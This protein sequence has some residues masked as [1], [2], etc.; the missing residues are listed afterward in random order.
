MHFV[1]CKLINL[2]YKYIWLTYFTYTL[3]R[4]QDIN[5]TSTQTWL[6]Y[7]ATKYYMTT[8]WPSKPAVP[9]LTT[10]M[11]SRLELIKGVTNTTVWLNDP[12]YMLFLS[13]VKPKLFV[14]EDIPF[15]WAG[16]IVT[17]SCCCRFP[18]RWRIYSTANNVLTSHP[19]WVRPI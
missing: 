5:F 8:L 4:Y 17:L 7:P 2:L 9:F 18:A 14:P 3:H 11:F 6:R 12:V 16:W 19:R 13:L 15:E 10:L 1:Q